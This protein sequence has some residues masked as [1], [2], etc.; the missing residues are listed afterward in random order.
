MDP[1][2]NKTAS[3]LF[4]LCF[5]RVPTQNASPQPTLRALP[6]VT[7]ISGGLDEYGRVTC[8]LSLSEQAPDSA[9]PGPPSV[10]FPHPPVGPDLLQPNPVMHI[11]S[12]PDTGKLNRGAFPG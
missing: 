2:T 7:T 5:Y 8:T 12:T 10:Q 6:P 1:V 11:E 3:D 4:F 9:T